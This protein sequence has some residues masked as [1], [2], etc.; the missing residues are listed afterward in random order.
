MII[1]IIL[2]LILAITIYLY[3]ETNWVVIKKSKLD[4]SLTSE[5]HYVHISDIHGK[6]RFINGLLFKKI[7]DLKADFVL[8]T[9]DYSNKQK[10]LSK[11]ISELSQINSNILMVLGNYE[12]EELVSLYKKRS[13]TLEV[14]EDEVNKYSNIRLLVNEE[15]TIHIDG[16]NIS[17]YGFDNSV[18]GNESYTISE[19]HMPIHLKLLLAHSPNIVHYIKDHNIDY[20]HLLVGHTHGKQI[21]LPLV[22]SS[23]DHF[24]IGT[25]HEDEGRYFS[26]TKGLGTVKLP[27]RIFAKPTIHHYKVL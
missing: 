22:H 15:K 4:M 13:I 24:H 6:T 5:L 14:L 11:V 16:I 21:N 8:V 18:Y 1:K 9:G 2:I 25:I 10:S 23:Y 7:N 3:F 20:N 12:R 27:I 17:I 26:I 19:T